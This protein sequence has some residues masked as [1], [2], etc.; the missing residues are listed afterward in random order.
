ML[1]CLFRQ[2]LSLMR[3]RYQTGKT[4]SLKAK[5][6]AM[7]AELDVTSIMLAREQA[8]YEVREKNI[9]AGLGICSFAARS[10]FRSSAVCSFALD[11]F[12]VGK[13]KTGLKHLFYTFWLCFYKKKS[14]KSDSLLSLFTKNNKEPFT[15]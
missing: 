5:I 7:E 9:S 4:S 13:L 2:L 1:T 14:E 15:L 8:K 11:T 6:K 12:N 3:K 10:L